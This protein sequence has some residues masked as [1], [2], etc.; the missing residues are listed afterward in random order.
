MGS[1]TSPFYSLPRPTPDE[2]RGTRPRREAARRPGVRDG[3]RLRQTQ[4]EVRVPWRS[5]LALQRQTVP[6]WFCELRS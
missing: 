3:R 4:A 2:R 5:A 6:L 1:V